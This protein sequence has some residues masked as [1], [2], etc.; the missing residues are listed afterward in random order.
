MSKS[1]APGRFWARI[2]DILEDG[3]CSA[4]QQGNNRARQQDPVDHEGD[5]GVVGDDLEEPNDHCISS[6]ECGLWTNMF[7]SS[8][9][10]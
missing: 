1:R 2:P 10:M 5:I 3:Q 8:E 6:I 9:N 7:F 4:S